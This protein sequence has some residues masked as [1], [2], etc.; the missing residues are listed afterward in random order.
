MRKIKAYFYSAI[1]FLAIK[2]F[3]YIYFQINP[4]HFI[5]RRQFRLG[6]TDMK[7]RKQLIY[8][9]T[10]NKHILRD[11]KFIVKTHKKKIIFPYLSRKIYVYI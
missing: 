1:L 8:S 2:L 3:L 4:K 9:K 11:S 7:K 6:E 10:V 5:F